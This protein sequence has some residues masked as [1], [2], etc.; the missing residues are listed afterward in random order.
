MTDVDLARIEA[1]LGITF[2]PSYRELVRTRAAEL[3][4]LTE[5]FRGEVRPWFEPWVFLSP[6]WLISANTFERSP[7]SAV[8]YSRP[9]WWQEYLLCGTDLGGDYFCL[10]LD[11]SPEVWL[12]EH[13]TGKVKF[14]YKSLAEHVEYRIERHREERRRSD[15]G[16]NWTAV[17]T[18]CDF[19][20][21]GSGGSFRYMTGDPCPK[22]KCTGKVIL[23]V[24]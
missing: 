6:D 4:G 20:A 23:A 3:A 12:L 21:S 7:E 1:E 10:R 16:P 24:R 13:E 17:C 9:G 19:E 8:G 5:A 22:D 11:G 15:S 18:K 14:R 2:P